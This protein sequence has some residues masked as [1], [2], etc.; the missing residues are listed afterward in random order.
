MVTLNTTTSTALSTTF[1]F[2]VGAGAGIGG[3][4]PFTAVQAVLPESDLP[5]G[6]GLSVFGLQLGTSLAFAIGQ[7]AFL[8]KVLRTLEENVLTKEIPRSDVIAA[9]AS[10]LEQL[11][12]T[13]EVLGTLRRAYS[14]GIRD[15]MIVALVA[16][17]LAN[18]CCFGMEWLKLGNVGEVGEVSE[19][20][21][22]IRGVSGDSVCT[23]SMESVKTTK[24]GVG[25][26]QTE[27]R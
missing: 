23:T 8:T 2:I 9:G 14:D 17:C 20:D 27:R 21:L 19:T 7:T 1:L 12:R 6:N 18:V 22:E 11:A 26:M 25:A 13:P 15:T 10:H 24:K 4:Q 3:N 16:I 5:L